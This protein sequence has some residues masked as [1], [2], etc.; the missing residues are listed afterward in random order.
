MWLDI[1]LTL[2]KEG[3]TYLRIVTT[4]KTCQKEFSKNAL[5]LI[6][7]TLAHWVCLVVQKY[8]WFFFAWD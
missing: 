3:P 8:S 7:L 1:I 4:L 6:G 2:N 5:S